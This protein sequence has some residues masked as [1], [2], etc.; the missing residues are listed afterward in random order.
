MDYCLL[1]GLIVTHS[2]YLASGAYKASELIH[3]LDTLL[4]NVSP[5]S[6]LS[7]FAQRGLILAQDTL[8]RLRKAVC[9]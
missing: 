5:D 8:S 7:S 2:D 3:A 4:R 6:P 9:R 1:L